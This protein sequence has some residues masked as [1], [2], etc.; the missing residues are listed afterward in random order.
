MTRRLIITRPLPGGMETAT[1]ASTLGIAAVPLPLQEVVAADWSMPEGDFDGLL[2]GSANAF[3]FASEGLEQVSDLRV[4]AVGTQTAVM[5]EA[6]GFRVASIG[7]DGLQSVIDALP[8]DNP[9]RLLRICGEDRIA[10]DPPQH[11]EIV[12]R[13]AYQLV[14]SEITKGQ[15]A[16]LRQPVCVAL[17]SAA[18]AQIFRS[19]CNDFGIDLANISILAFSQRIADAAGAGWERVLVADKP[20]DDAL[21]ALAKPLCQ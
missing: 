7:A 14:E 12:E 20:S 9:L 2:I 15:A 6:S 3:R 19:V 17:H 1:R 10:L 18:S 16:L 5:A 8:A 21:L 13:I 11:V 4:H